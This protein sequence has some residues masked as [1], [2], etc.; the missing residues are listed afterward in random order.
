MVK[1]QFLRND[2]KQALPR[3]E[4]L[5]GLGCTLRIKQLLNSEQ[6]EYTRCLELINKTNQFNTTGERWRADEF[7]RF[8]NEQQGQVYSF[9]VRDKFVSYGLVGVVIIKGSRIQQFIM[10][11]RV[12]GMD[13]EVSVIKEIVELLRCC[14]GSESIAARLVETQENT[15]CRQVYIK[16]GFVNDAANNALFILDAAK[17]PTEAAHVQIEEI[18]VSS[19][20]FNFDK[21][22]LNRYK[23]VA[24]AHALG[25]M[26][27]AE[28]HYEVHGKEEARFC[29]VIL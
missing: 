12:L 7:A 26:V 4:F 19:Y 14:I 13:V 11:C 27:S 10:S 17:Q 16:S 9:S 23:D 25:K 20:N 3:D 29:P 18:E 22:Y 28:V 5:F 2:E 1:S 15:P 21:W 8:V 6:P 24:E